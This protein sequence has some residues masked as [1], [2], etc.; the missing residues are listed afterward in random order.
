[1]DCPGFGATVE[2]KSIFKPFKESRGF[3][4]ADFCPDDEKEGAGGFDADG[5]GIEVD[6]PAFGATGEEKS[7]F[8]DFK[9]SCGFDMADFCPDDD[10]VFE[11]AD[12][13]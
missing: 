10:E 4:M 12:A 11:F 6:F 13:E 5:G 7:I 3:D 9:E 8:K 1:M 2:E